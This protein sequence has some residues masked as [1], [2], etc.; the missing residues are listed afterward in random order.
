MGSIGKRLSVVG[1]SLLMG[2]LCTGLYAISGLPAGWDWNA[3]FEAW[4]YMLTGPI[5]LAVLGGGPVPDVVDRAVCLGWLGLPALAAHP[6]DPNVWTAVATAAGAFF[7][8]ASGI[9][10]MIMCVWGA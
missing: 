2:A 9:L 3:R 7:W 5:F 4:T 6:I 8:F 10:L 1:P